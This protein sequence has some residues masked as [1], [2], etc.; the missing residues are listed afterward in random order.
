MNLYEN[1]FSVL[2][3]SKTEGYIG[4]KIS[5]LDHAL[6]S[7]YFAVESGHSD[8][9][10]IASLFHDI[11]HYVS[12]VPVEHMANLGV[13]NHE[14][15]AAKHLLMWGFS[16]RVVNLVAN[17]VNAKRYLSANNDNYYEKLSDASK[18][19]LKFQGGLMDT[20]EMCEFE[21]S[22]Y[23]TESIQVRI[24]DERAKEPILKVPSLSAYEQ[25]VSKHLASQMELA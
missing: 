21:S 1:A 14:L 19:T 16:K 2:K 10:I 20:D 12:S 9:V 18:G 24:N 8:S 5:Q 7:A 13:L 23:F 6:Q 3:S 22:P 25:L 4:E 15:I 17:H 11:G